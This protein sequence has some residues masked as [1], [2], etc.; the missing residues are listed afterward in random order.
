[1]SS[2]DA[3]TQ[4]QQSKG[5]ESFL[6]YEERLALKR[7]LSFPEELPPE[8]KEWVLDYVST[9]IELEPYK[10]Q[11][12]AALDAATAA[13]AAASA[14]IA[15]VSAAQIHANADLE[16]SDQSTSSTTY[17]DLGG[18]ELTGLEDGDYILLYGCRMQTNNSLTHF[19][20]PLI[21][22]SGP[23]DADAAQGRGPIIASVARAKLQTLSG[24][25]NS[26][27]MRYRVDTST[28]GFG[29]RWLVAVRL[30]S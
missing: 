21:N 4:Q 28:G 24:G 15:A 3:E 23:S 17:T 26:I 29:D 6:S 22:G 7:S 9:G 30:G 11:T 18:P 1:M 8:H 19:Y 27:A 13:Q 25:S 12:K 10:K 2:F 16:S 5:P 14:A 20:S